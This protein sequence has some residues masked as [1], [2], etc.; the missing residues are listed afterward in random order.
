[1]LVAN[2]CEPMQDHKPCRECTVYN[3]TGWV[4]GENC[5]GWKSSS[6][7]AFCFWIGMRRYQIASGFIASP[8]VSVRGFADWLLLAKG[9]NSMKHYEPTPYSIKRLPPPLQWQCSSQFGKTGKLST[10]KKRE[11]HRGNR[12]FEHLERRLYLVCKEGPADL[13]GWRTGLKI[14]CHTGFSSYVSGMPKTP[15]ALRS[16]CTRPLHIWFCLN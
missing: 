15:L 6:H 14:S 9:D 5:T 8:A 10:R 1:M 11:F 12:M 7:T 3:F 16:C 4:C 2:V 13:W